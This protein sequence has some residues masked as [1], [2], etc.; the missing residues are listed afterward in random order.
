MALRITDFEVKGDGVT[1]NTTAI[2]AII[3]TCVS[4]G[5]WLY[6]PYGTYLISDNITNFHSVIHKGQGVVKRGSTLFYLAPLN[7]QSN[8]IYISATGDNNNDGL[9]SSYPKQTFQAAFDTLRGYG[10]LLT[11]IWNVVAAAGTYEISAGQQTFSTRSYN[12]V[13]IRGETAGHPNVPTTIIDG[14]GNQGSYLHGLSASGVGVKVEFRDLKFIRFT[15]AS[16]NTRI[17]LL[18]ENEVDF[19]TNNIH[20]DACSWTGI[21]AFNVIRCRSKGGIIDANSIGSYGFVTNCS[22]TTLGYT[23]S[24]TSEG[25]IIKNALTSGVYWSR[26]SQGHLDYCTLTD[27]TIGFTVAE[28][29]RCHTVGCD[30]KRNTVGISARTGGVF[31]DAGSDA[32]VFNNGTVDANTTNIEYKAFSGDTDELA[33]SE[34][35]IRVGYDR[36]LRTASGITSGTFPTIYTLPAYRMS[37]TGKTC[38]LHVKGIYTVTSGS[39]IIAYFGGMSLSLTVG[40]AGTSVAFELDV[41]LMEVAGGYRAI[42]SLRHGLSAQRYGTASSG[43]DKTATQDIAVGYN[44]TGAGDSV[45]IYRSN[46]YLLG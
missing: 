14:G 5:D 44:L 11:G 37:G 32:N 16:G 28:N 6:W 46:V 34:S 3:D 24:Q 21:Y 35:W 27:N 17:G 19:Y 22:Q 29:S 40:A 12:R 26:G 42:G 23:A 31:G 2:Q 41:E 25:V 10:P 1:D 30:F 36:T 38:R 13:V 7:S 9:T 43:F 45:N 33:T 15:E 20:T 18:G 39:V 8:T 4:S